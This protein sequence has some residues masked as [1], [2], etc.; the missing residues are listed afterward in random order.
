MKCSEIKIMYLDANECIQNPSVCRENSNC[1]NTEGS[2]ACEC[3][4]GYTGDGK[5]NCSGMFYIKI[6]YHNYIS[7]KASLFLEFDM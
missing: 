6:A 3:L 5:H 2:Y 1:T 7:F 4:R